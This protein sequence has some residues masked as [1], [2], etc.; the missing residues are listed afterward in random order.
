MEARI[1]ILIMFLKE[2]R[3]EGRQE[4]KMV[5]ESSRHVNEKIRVILWDRHDFPLVSA[6]WTLNRKKN[7]YGRNMEIQTRGKEQRRLAVRGES[8]MED[9]TGNKWKKWIDVWFWSVFIRGN[10]GSV[11]QG[12]KAR[13]QTVTKPW[14]S[15]PHVPLPAPSFLIPFLLLFCP[16]LLSFSSN[17]SPLLCIT[18][19]AFLSFTL[20]FFSFCHP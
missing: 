12:P 15:L 14:P 7:G 17:L 20:L 4:G 6:L 16:P 5:S 1:I 2:A 13:V 11:W 9:E 10:K 8:E 18:S 3:K 19:T